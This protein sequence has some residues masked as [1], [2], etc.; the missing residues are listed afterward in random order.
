MT[1]ADALKKMD[2]H[3]GYASHQD[4]MKFA[5]KRMIMFGLRVARIGDRVYVL[6]RSRRRLDIYFCPDASTIELEPEVKS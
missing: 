3:E 5:V 6:N 2:H 4:T 1:L